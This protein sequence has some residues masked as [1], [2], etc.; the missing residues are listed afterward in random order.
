MYSEFDVRHERLDQLG[1]ERIRDTRNSTSRFMA[2]E[3]KFK[4]DGYDLVLIIIGEN[5]LVTN[6]WERLS[7]SG[8]ESCG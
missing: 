3:R 6:N 4:G 7:T 8:F 5:K 2:E 1:T